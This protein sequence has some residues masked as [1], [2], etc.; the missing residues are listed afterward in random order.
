MGRAG[1]GQKW[2][3]LGEYSQRPGPSGF[4]DQAPQLH[5][6]LACVQPVAWFPDFRWTPGLIQQGKRMILGKVNVPTLETCLQHV[7]KKRG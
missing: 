2:D 5:L 7:G 6:Q 1:R 4:A 3:K